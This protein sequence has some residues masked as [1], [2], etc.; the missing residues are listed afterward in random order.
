MGA[1]IANARRPTN[2]VFDTATLIVSR[3]VTP[4][5]EPVPG[6]ERRASAQPA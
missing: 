1:V 6:R 5:T 2:V 3:S 4:A